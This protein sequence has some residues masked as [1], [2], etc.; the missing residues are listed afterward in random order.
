MLPTE[1][2]SNIIKF[3]HQEALFYTK[4]DWDFNKDSGSYQHLYILSDDEIKEGDW[5]VCLD[6]IDTSIMNW[7]IELAVF[8]FNGGNCT[9]D[10]KIIAT[11][12][13]SL[14]LP[15]PSNEFIKKYCELGGIDEILVEYEEP[16]WYKDSEDDTYFCLACGTEGI[17]RNIWA[18]KFTNCKCSGYKLAPD[19]TITVYSV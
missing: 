14:G 10:K 15:R 9:S 4:K 6:E 5:I 12:D 19:N 2:I 3:H 18:T 13:K 11:T 17:E 1:K 16:Q 8:Q 7:D